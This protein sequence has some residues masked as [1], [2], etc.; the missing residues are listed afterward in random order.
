MIFTTLGRYFFRRYIVTALWFLLGV[1]AII[2][3]R[4]SCSAHFTQQ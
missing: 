1:S 3:T 4:P 2:S